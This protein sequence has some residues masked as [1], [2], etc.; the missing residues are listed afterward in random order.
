[1]RAHSG[2]GIPAKLRAD[3]GLPG[4]AQIGS[5]G[6]ASDFAV[7][8]TLPPYRRVWDISLPAQ[9]TESTRYAMEN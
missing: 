7:I 1:V 4:M 5:A 9:S 2:V 6:I 8:Q 3:D